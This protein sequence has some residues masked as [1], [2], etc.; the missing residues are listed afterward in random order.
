MKNALFTGI[1]L[2]F[3][4]LYSSQSFDK[5]AHRGGKSLY[6]ENTI[7]AM[8]NG[9]KMNVTTLEMDLA[10]TKDKKVILSHDAFLSPE[11]VTKPDGTYIPKDSGFYYKIYEMP[12]AKIKTFDVGLK[13]LNNYPDQKKMKAQKPLFSDVIDACEAYARE[14]KRPLPFYNIETKTRPFSDNIF[15]PE[16]KEFVDLMMKIIVEKNIQDRVIIQSF[17]PRTLEILHKEYPKIMTA[18]LVEKVDDKKLAQQQAYFKNISV[19]KFKMYPDHLSGVAGDMKFLS[20]TPTI[21][22]PEHNLV[23]SQLVQEC[24]SL[25]MKVIPWTVNTR[26]RLKELKEM[27]IDGVISDDPRIFE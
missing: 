24:H 3:T 5:Q 7:P 11:L 6:P 13:K 22:S 21:Y 2:V 17:D 14:L 15:H 12:Y 27:G 25:G 18:L 8:K 20:F 23:T 1:F 10:V 19:E 4:Q 26:E 16:P 9:L